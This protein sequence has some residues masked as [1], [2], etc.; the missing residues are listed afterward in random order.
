MTPEGNESLMAQSRH[1][2]S[3]SGRDP[4]GPVKARQQWQPW[5]QKQGVEG[6]HRKLKYKTER[7]REVEI[8]LAF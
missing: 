4:D 2:N 8:V 3:G 7:E 1:S 5:W 6:C